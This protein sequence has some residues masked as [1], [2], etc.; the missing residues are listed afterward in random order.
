VTP[1]ANVPSLIAPLHIWPYPANVG[2][3]SW[4]VQPKVKTSMDLKSQA[5]YH[6]GDLA[7]SE[8]NEKRTRCRADRVMPEFGWTRLLSI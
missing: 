6:L 5:F 7:L 2:L 8:M 3:F 1:V 4:R